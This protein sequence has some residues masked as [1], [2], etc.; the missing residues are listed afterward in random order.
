MHTITRRTGPLSTSQCR[1]A[2]ISIKMGQAGR[3]RLLTTNRLA[4]GEP[5]I[6]LERGLGHPN[7]KVPRLESSIPCKSDC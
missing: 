6:E 5:S 7:P 1:Y 2:Q 4:K 3:I